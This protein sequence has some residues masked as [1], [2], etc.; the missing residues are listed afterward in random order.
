M[1]DPAI[2]DDGRINLPE[3]T[4]EALE[5]AAEDVL[6]PTAPEALFNEGGKVFRGA[7]G[8]FFL[9]GPDEP[10]GVALVQADRELQERLMAE[11]AQVRKAQADEGRKKYLDPERNEFIKK[12]GE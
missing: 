3:P 2:L 11:A 10:I 1:S 12:T 8:N 5:K 4:A 6:G 9:Q 7:A